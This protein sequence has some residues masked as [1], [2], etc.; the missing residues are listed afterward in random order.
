M[1]NTHIC[2][3]LFVSAYLNDCYKTVAKREMVVLLAV[4]AVCLSF[5]ATRGSCKVY[6][7]LV[8]NDSNTICHI[9]EY[10]NNT[11][12]IITTLLNDE[13]N[14]QELLKSL[15]PI[16]VAKPQFTLFIFFTNNTPIQKEVCSKPPYEGLILELDGYK[17]VHGTMWYS[18]TTNQ[19]FATDLLYE[20]GLIYPQY[21]SGVLLKRNPYLV[22]Y[23][24]VCLTLPFLI[25]DNS[26][27]FRTSEALMKVTFVVSLNVNL[28][29]VK[30]PHKQGQYMHTM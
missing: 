2:V 28:G 5:L 26:G 29:L 9:H 15:Y 8:S 30:K 13:S 1:H 14:Y 24:A 6:K 17:N 18:S 23:S 11:D 10:C 20:L 21:S 4:V 19:V 12:E 27:T 22:E 16:N 25:S 7:G 3:F